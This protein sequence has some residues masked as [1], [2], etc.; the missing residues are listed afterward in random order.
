MDDLGM[1]A[2]HSCFDLS[3]EVMD[4]INAGKVSF[5]IDQQQTVAQNGEHANYCSPSLRRI[6]QV[7]FLEP[8]SHPDLDF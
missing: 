6:V 8:K 7:C 3:P 4:L 5:T 1:S 2:H